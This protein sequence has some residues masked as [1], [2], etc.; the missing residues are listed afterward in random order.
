MFSDRMD[1][2]NSRTEL[3]SSAS[4]SLSKNHGSD[5]RL[6]ET[7]RKYEQLV[8]YAPAAIYEIDF[9]RR[10]FT[11]V[12]DAMCALSGPLFQVSRVFWLQTSSSPQ[13]G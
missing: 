10:R 3:E 9:R 4:G 12:N 5:E 7:E 2:H 8:R 1:K 13:E 6:R 11:S